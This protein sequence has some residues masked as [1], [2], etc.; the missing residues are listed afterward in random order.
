MHMLGQRFNRTEQAGALTTALAPAP[1]S[2]SA[3]PVTMYTMTMANRNVCIAACS[4]RVDED[5]GM[6]SSARRRDCL[7]CYGRT[8]QLA[9][10]GK[11]QADCCDHTHNHT[12]QLNC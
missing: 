9:C 7:L 1:L 12:S 6:M 11:L 2:K 10:M 4:G 3:D 8:V 5:V